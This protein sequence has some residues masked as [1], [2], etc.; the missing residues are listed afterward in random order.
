MKIDETRKERLR[1]LTV[2]FLLDLYRQAIRSGWSALDLWDQMS[3]RLRAAART[4]AGPDEW[5]SAM[6]RSLKQPGPGK[7]SS[8]SLIDL[9]AQVREWACAS[10]WLDLLEREH[11]LLIA[12]ARK[13]NEERRAAALAAQTPDTTT[14]TA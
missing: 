8:G 1:T 11:G 5:T 13:L 3:T 7:D 12:M 6:L 2:E 10:A 4:S 9:T 14:E